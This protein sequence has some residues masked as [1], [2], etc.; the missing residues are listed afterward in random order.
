MVAVSL[1]REEQ[2]NDVAATADLPVGSWRP[3]TYVERSL[4][5]ASPSIRGAFPAT[6]IV[7]TAASSV[8]RALAT[9]R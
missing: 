1:K 2:V 9:E 4:A 8:N 3:P 7:N 5:P 6:D